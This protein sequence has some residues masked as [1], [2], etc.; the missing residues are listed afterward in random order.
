M[1][2]VLGPVG[3]PVET[4][5]VTAL[6]TPRQGHAAFVA[7]VAPGIAVRPF[8]LFVNK[9]FIESERHAELTWGAAHA[10]VATGV[11][12]AV[13]EG[14]IAEAD[15]PSLLL[16]VAVWVNPDAGDEQVVFSNNREA[17]LGAL[18]AGREGGPE[19]AAALRAATF[20]FQRLL[21]ALSGT[22]GRCRPSAWTK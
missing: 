8:T 15:V 20:A 22:V 10:G 4:A 2:T 5:W 17:T 12:D 18:R 11:M 16:V 3:G 21:S 13:A 19:V 1:N 7:S 14:T 9:A 6:A